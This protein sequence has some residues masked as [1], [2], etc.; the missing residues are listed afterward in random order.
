[1]IA[2]NTSYHPVVK[3][4]SYNKMQEMLKSIN[5]PFERI[6]L[7]GR[8]IT[9]ACKGEK[10]ADN[11]FLVLKSYVK[12]PKIKNISSFFRP[13]AYVVGGLI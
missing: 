10:L 4:G 1:M 3:T 13:R 9:I 2:I 6:N 5:L 8:V 11:W 12:R 7:T